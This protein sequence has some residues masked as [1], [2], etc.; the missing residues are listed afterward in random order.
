MILFALTIGLSAF[1]LFAVQPVIA[2]MILPWF[3]GSS[4]LWST[5]MLFFQL[6][7][8]L[9]Y[10]YAHWLNE[11]L[12]P[13]VQAAVHTAALAISLAAL[14]ILPNPIWKSAAG[15]PSLKILA[16]L[17]ATIGLPYFLLSSTGPLMQA[18]YARTHKSGMPYRLFALSN[19]ASML[20]LLSYPLLAE[21]N[22]PTRLQGY[23][24]SAAYAVFAVLCAVTAWRACLGTAGAPRLRP[25]SAADPANASPSVRLLWFGLAAS[26]SILL[27]AVTNHMTQDIAA[28]PFLWIVPLAV[29]LLS[30]IVCFEAPRLYNRMFFLPLLVAAFSFMMRQMWTE[31]APASLVRT[32]EFLA[33]SLFVVCMACHGELARLKPHPRHLTGFYAIVSLGGA[34]GGLFVGLAAPNIFRAYYEFPLGLGFCAALIAL[35]YW[36]ETW[37]NPAY[38]RYAAAAGLIAAL[39][40]YLWCVGHVLNRMTQGYRLVA[41]NF[42]GQLRIIDDGDPRYQ[43]E[44]SRTLVHGTINHGAQF[45]REEYRRLPVTYF[46]PESGVGRGMRALGGEGRR[47]GVIGMGCGTLA[48]YG[49]PGDALRIYEINPLVWQ[50]AKTQ[51]T[52]LEDTPAKLDVKMGD[53]RLS[54]EA[55]PSQQF[56]I[57]VV[58]AF[59]G[60][61]IPVHLLTVEA[62]RLYFRHL[63][64]G[65]ILALNTTN[66]YLDLNPVMAHA[67]AAFGK[68]AMHY[69]FVA[70][71]EEFICFDCDWT[72]IMDR[73]TLAAHPGLERRAVELKPRAAFTTWTDDFSNLYGILR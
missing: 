58:D 55:E 13:R 72:L 3:G 23:S 11:K 62:F 22:L 67:A 36:R 37:P 60:D 35:V 19:L 34:M 49:K 51:F 53:A 1:L 57:L 48:A 73:S 44:A 54:L 27:L 52:Y 47:I 5:C 50:I 68:I 4:A 32:I 24:W 20:A 64:P 38:I 17:A 10:L 8:L 70:P 65:G 56:D 46:C 30:F 7:L 26:A 16:L 59:S 25:V 9:G 39:A 33:A 18:W 2:K 15:A 71:P 6:T 42:Y 31:D 40:G 14:P 69:S 41:R 29:Y 43:E 61:A 45:Q 12:R 63:K 21:P 66:R 28:I